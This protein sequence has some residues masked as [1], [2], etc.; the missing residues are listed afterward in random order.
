MRLAES[1]ADVSEFLGL[2]LRQVYLLLGIATE[3][4]CRANSPRV[5]PLPDHIRLA[6]RLLVAL[7]RCEQKLKTRPEQ[8]ALIQQDLR[9]FYERLRR[10]F[11]PR[12][13]PNLPV[14]ADSVSTT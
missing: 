11:E 10:F 3:P 4:K 14:P 13:A 12:A 2:S 5:R 6:N 7:S 1:T 9:A 8:G